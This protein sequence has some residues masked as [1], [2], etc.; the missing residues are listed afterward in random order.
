MG[1]SG[2]GHPPACYFDDDACKILV[3]E[4]F[5]DTIQAAIGADEHHVG[6]RALGAARIGKLLLTILV[7]PVHCWHAHGGDDFG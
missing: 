2:A 5:F 4:Y 3:V 6:L 1:R 7:L